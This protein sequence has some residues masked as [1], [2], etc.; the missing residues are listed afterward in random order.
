MNPDSQLFAQTIVLGAG[1]GIGAAVTRALAAKNIPVRAI[2][3]NC[4]RAISQ[5]GKVEFYP[6]DVLQ[7]DEIIAACR[8]AKI[9]YYCANAP[10]HQWAELLP[11]MLENVIAAAAH[12]NA[13]LI[14]ADNL[15]MYP[16]STDPLV[17]TLPYAPITQKG[18]IR[19]KLSEKIMTAHQQGSIRAAIG[20]APDY[21]GPSALNS[22]IINTRTMNALRNHKALPWIVSA[23]QPHAIIYVDD[24]AEGL[25]ILSQQEK[26]L[27]EIWNIPSPQAI[28]GRQF[29]TILQEEYDAQI[30]A[31]PRS[32]SVKIQVFAPWMLLATGMFDPI[33]REIYEMRY[34]FDR[35]YL[36][37]ATKFLQAFGNFTSTPHRLAIRQTIQNLQLDTQ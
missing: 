4:R 7:K 13:K 15:Y 11:I 34:E 22:L 37:D 30:G 26:A 25:L 33:V 5:D 2:S 8:D 9:I 24:F 32:H 36:V 29:L 12:A 35:P 27:G 3:R 21:Y 10:Y 16:P 20:R 28:T 6:A 19:V 1:S 31:P 23:D 14:L 17:E 18:K